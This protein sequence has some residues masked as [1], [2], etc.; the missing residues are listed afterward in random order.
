MCW[1]VCLIGFFALQLYIHIIEFQKYV[2]KV[3]KLHE[4]Y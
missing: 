4:D 1:G 2:T 3:C